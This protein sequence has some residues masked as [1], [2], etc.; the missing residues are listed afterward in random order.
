[1]DLRDFW[2]AAGAYQEAG[3]LTGARSAVLQA[4]EIA[5]NFDAA[6]ELLL[7]LRSGLLGES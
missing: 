2:E 1:M 6:L 3:D 7:I 5:P 4:L